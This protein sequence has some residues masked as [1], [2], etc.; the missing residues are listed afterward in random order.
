MLAAAPLAG[1]ADD[2]HHGNQN[3]QGSYQQCNQYGQCTW[4]NRG[5]G[6]EDNDDQGAGNAHNCVNPAGHVRGWCKH[7]GNTN[8]NGNNG[9]Y[10][11]QNQQ[12]QGV[13]TGV[14]GSSVTLLQGLSSITIDASQA[15]QRGNTNGPLYVTR[16][17]T[18]YGYYDNNG[19]FH[20]T[21]IR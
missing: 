2:E 20:A 6:N 21:Q 12:L 14:R 5:N 7:H 3:N 15:L 1:F 16:S 11:G 19:Y 10:Y 18:A 17:I 13:V 9:G 8:Y 4:Y